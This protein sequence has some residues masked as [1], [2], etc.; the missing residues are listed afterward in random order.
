MNAIPPPPP[1]PIYN[2][3]L[4]LLGPVA[5]NLTFDPVSKGSAFA[6]K[7]NSLH[8]HVVTQVVSEQCSS[9]HVIMFHIKTQVIALIW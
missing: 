9:K 2:P 1:T 8:F 5:L 6:L 7:S 4:A 3:S